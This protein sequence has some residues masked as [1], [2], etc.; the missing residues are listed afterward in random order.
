MHEDDGK[1]YFDDMDSASLWKA[2]IISIRI[3]EKEWDQIV[4]PTSCKGKVK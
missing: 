4:D 3:N 1:C 2:H